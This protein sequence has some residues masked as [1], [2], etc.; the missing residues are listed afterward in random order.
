MDGR[1]LPQLAAAFLLLVIGGSGLAAGVTITMAMT[2]ASTIPLPGIEIGSGVALY[3]GLTAIAGFGLILR[4]RWSWLLGVATI[5][6]GG[7]FLVG[8]VVVLGGDEVFS[9]GI[10]LWGVTLTCLLAPATRASL[11]P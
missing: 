9:F 5:V 7:L 8:L 6:G 1:P 3:G 2:K 11:R 4:R 10:A